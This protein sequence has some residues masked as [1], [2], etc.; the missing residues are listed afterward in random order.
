ML[1]KNINFYFAITKN[2][3]RFAATFV[4]NKYNFYTFTYS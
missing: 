2:I 1:F 4:S 3:H